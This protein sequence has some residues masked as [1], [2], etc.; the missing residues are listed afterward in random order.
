MLSNYWKKTYTLRCIKENSS[1]DS[2]ILYKIGRFILHRIFENNSFVQLK[3]I[4]VLLQ[5]V[6]VKT[7]RFI[8]T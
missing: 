7:H 6:A 2:K 4:E 5:I 3:C 8:T 1:I